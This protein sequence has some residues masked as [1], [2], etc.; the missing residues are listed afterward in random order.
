MDLQQYMKKE[1]LRYAIGRQI[2]CP[3]K[4]VVLDVREAVLVE[5][6]SGRTIAV[7]CREAFTEL[8]A[9]GIDPSLVLTKGWEL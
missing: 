5:T 1:L 4:G 2:T 6:D 9:Q 3:I 7:I 8:E